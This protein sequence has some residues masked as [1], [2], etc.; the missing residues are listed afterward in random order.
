MPPYTGLVPFC[1]LCKWN[2]TMDYMSAYSHNQ[3][4]VYEIDQ[5]TERLS[6]LLVVTQLVRG[7]AR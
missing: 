6:S 1:T 4:Y 7:G 5:G 3:H 2:Y